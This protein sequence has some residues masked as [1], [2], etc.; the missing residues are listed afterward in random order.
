MNLN[1]LE[2]CNSPNFA[3]FFTEFDSFTAHYVTV[4]ED[5]PVMSV[6]Y[7]LSVSVVHFWLKTNAPHNAVSLRQLNIS[8]I[9]EPLY[10]H[11]F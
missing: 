3:F 6:K 9:P 8:F 1:D 7:I 5:R 10:C 11:P 4:V 2:R